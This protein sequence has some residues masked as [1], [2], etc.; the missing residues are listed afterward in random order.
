[1][2]MKDLALPG[3]TLELPQRPKK[4]RGK[5]ITAITDVGIPLGE[6]IQIL[7][8]YHSLLDMAKLGIGSAYTEPL[9]REKISCYQEHGIPVYFGG[10]L[11]EKYYSQGKLTDYLHFLDGC[12]IDCIEISSGTLDIRHQEE[13][14]LI[15]QLKSNFTVLVEV[16][17]KNNTPSFTDDDW[18]TYTQ[19]G[20]DA[21][22]H[23]VVLEGRNTA[24]AG[25]YNSD[26][27]LD[28]PLIEKIAKTVDTNHLI[29]EAPTSKSQSQLI[30]I[31][32]TNVNLGNVFARDL[33]LLETQRVGLREETFFIP[34][35]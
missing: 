35:K 28:R 8:S 13:V 3:K 5:G 11:F 6:L 10:T 16:G 24:D 15:K 21:G 14:T 22:C 29:F 27:V 19:N 33:L 18:I 9:L 25:I 30:N 4:P 17:K 32:G 31:F 7:D 20:I 26:G 23:Y 34:I 1:M 2:K 12:G